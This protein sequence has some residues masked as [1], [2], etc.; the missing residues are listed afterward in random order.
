MDERD[1]LAE[2]F[3]ASRPHLRAVA[4]RVLGSG[5]ALRGFTIRAGKVTAIEMIADP[6]RIAGL[7]VIPG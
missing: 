4:Y 3:E 6:E 7:E 1:W 2:R 5:R